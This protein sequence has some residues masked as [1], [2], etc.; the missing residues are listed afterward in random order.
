M[1]IRMM[2]RTSA[3]MPIYMPT[4]SGGYARAVPVRMERHAPDGASVVG[5]VA[6]VGRQRAALVGPLLDPAG[7]RV[8]VEARGPQRLR[9][10]E[11]AAAD[12]AHEDHRALGVE[13]GGARGELCELDVARSGHVAGLALVVLAHVDDL[14]RLVRER[15]GR[16]LGGDLEPVALEW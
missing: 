11:R 7:H 3:P 1:M 2:I 15:P 10:H 8:R 6:A 9:G 5:D 14:G 16:A 13:L 12:P 4:P